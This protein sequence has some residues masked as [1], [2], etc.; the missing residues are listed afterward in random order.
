MYIFPSYNLMVWGLILLV[1]PSCVLDIIEFYCSF[2][3]MKKIQ[4]EALVVNLTTQQIQDGPG[5]VSISLSHWSEP[6]SSCF[7]AN[8]FCFPCIHWSNLMLR[9]LKWCQD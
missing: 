5:S 3:G 7:N 2:Y 1:T 9:P 4:E 8:T 6:F